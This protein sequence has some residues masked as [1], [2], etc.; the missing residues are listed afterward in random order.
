MRT[1][2]KR[3]WSERKHLIERQNR[4]SSLT[5]GPV[6]GTTWLPDF[7]T[8]PRCSCTWN[9]QWGRWIGSSV[10]ASSCHP[11]AVR[12]RIR[13]WPGPGWSDASSD[14]CSIAKEIKTAVDECWIHW[15]TSS[16]AVEHPRGANGSDHLAKYNPRGP[17][18]TRESNETATQGD[19]ND[20]ACLDDGHVTLN[21]CNGFVQQVFQRGGLL[22]LLL[23]VFA[24]QFHPTGQLRKLS[25]VLSRLAGCLQG[26]FVIVEESGVLGQHRFRQI[27]ERLS[28]LSNYHMWAMARPDRTFNY[29]T[30]ATC[31]SRMLR[32][33]SKL[34][35]TLCGGG[36]ALGCWRRCSKFL[37]AKWQAASYWGWL[38]VPCCTELPSSKRPNNFPHFPGSSSVQQPVS[39]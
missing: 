23:R 28:D 7:R 8:T 31:S 30:P 27:A 24:S 3:R 18:Q 36:K 9:K 1:S 39:A 5:H 29:F 26:V 15:E 10:A 37:L 34:Q 13:F 32:P 4:R 21:T 25:R 16:S 20:E 6:S 35:E 14:V 11:T 22:L 33:F 12:P 2:K 17:T 19:G 38:P